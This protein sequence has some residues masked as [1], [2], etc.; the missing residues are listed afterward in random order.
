[1]EIRVGSI[2]GIILTAQ[3]EPV[4]VPLYPP[5]SHIDL[6]GLAAGFLHQ[7]NS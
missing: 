4:S 7:L 6:P 5:K 1:M 3:E 2:C